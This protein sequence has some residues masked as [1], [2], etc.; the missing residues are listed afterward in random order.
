MNAEGDRVARVGHAL[1]H[2]FVPTVDG[3]ISTLLGV[4]MLSLTSFEFIFKYFFLLYLVIVLVGVINGIVIL[5]V[6]L[7]LV[8]PPSL[9]EGRGGEEPV[10]PI[11]KMGQPAVDFHEKL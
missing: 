2:M 10:S 8:G 1:D 11:A 9:N 7:M 3:S 4:L 5:P 6:V